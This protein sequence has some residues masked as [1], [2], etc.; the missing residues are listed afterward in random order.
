MTTGCL[1]KSEPKLVEQKKAARGPLSYIAS[2][3]TTLLEPIIHVEVLDS[4]QDRLVERQEDIG[5]VH[6]A[7]EHVGAAVEP[8]WPEIALPPGVLVAESVWTQPQMMVT[9]ATKTRPRRCSA[10]QA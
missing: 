8:V 4:T 3:S 5:L 1:Y 2:Q 9:V 7:G 10:W 6:H